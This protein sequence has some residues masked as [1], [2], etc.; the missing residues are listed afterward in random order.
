MATERSLQNMQSNPKI[1]PRVFALPNSDQLLVFEPMALETFLQHRQTGNL[2]E[3]GGLL[4][5]E[6]QLPK[7]IIT[8]V[9]KPEASDI[10]SRNSFFPNRRKQQTAIRAQFERGKHFVGEWHTHPEPNP[11]PS[12]MDLQSMAESFVRSRHELNYFILVIVG[13]EQARSCLSVSAHDGKT[14]QVLTEIPQQ[15][16][17]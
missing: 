1:V 9:S 6:F 12:R 5:A 13:N 2:P 7:V 14:A 3:A 15:E 11:S 17:V 8:A 16:S 4:F 10:R